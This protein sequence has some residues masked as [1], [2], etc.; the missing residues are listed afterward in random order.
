MSETIDYGKKPGMH[1]APM[2]IRETDENGNPPEY[3]TIENTEWT[4]FYRLAYRRTDD[5]NVYSLI[6][7][8]VAANIETKEIEAE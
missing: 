1:P 5:W 2:L 7:V 3:V 4:A 6:G 8:T